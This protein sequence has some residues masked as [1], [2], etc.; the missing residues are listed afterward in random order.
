MR[1]AA[2]LIAAALLADAAQADEARVGCKAGDKACALPKIRA[3]AVRKLE[4]W[5]D[6]MARPLQERIGLGGPELVDYLTL[7]N[8][9]NA[10]PQRPRVPA[11]D[12]AFLAEVRAAIAELPVAVKR[13][14]ERKLA[15]IYLVEEIG[16]TGFTDEVSDASG[17]P[18]AGFIVLDPTVL[19]AHSANSWITWREN[20]PFK[21]E[22]GHTLSA[23]IAPDG[24]NDRKGAIQYILL[25]ELAHVISIGGKVHPSWTMS[26]ADIGPG[27][28][29]PYF[30]LSWR[31]G[32]GGYTTLFDDAFPERRSVVYYFGPRLEGAQMKAA[33]DSLERTNFA[34]LY[35]ATHPGDDFAEAFA[36]YVHVVLMGKPFEIAIREGGRPVKAYRPCWEEQRCAAKRRMIEALLKP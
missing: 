12:A 6:A 18:V 5:K 3:H 15:G 36:N 33:Y 20:T 25:H 17:N 23:R 10:Y 35:S 27:S 32:E 31:G 26:P 24:A 21:P 16:G 11:S 29:F 28:A 19:R 14:L 13:L 9:A 30:E 7:D 2:L 4:F 34:T 22:V 1:L 8:L